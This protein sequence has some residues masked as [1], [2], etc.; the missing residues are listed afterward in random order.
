MIDPQLQARTTLDRELA[1]LRDNVLRLSY[2]VDTAIERSVQSLKD[3]DAALAQQVIADD[4]PINHMRYQIEEACY[5]LLAM[6]QPTARDMRSIVTAIH[7]VVE[8]ERIGDH[9]AGI[10]KISIELAKEPMLKPLI[11]VPRMAEISREMMR[12]SLNAYLEWDA[13]QARQTALRD[14]EVDTLDDQ[15]YRELLSFMLEDAHNIARATHLLWVSHNLERIADR[16]TNICERVIFMVTGQV[17]EI[18][19]HTH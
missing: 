13:E 4:E 1:T 16:I 11:D 12:A 18:G 15:V 3:Q 19:D 2:M 14:S 6:Q 8:L 9:A 10:A 7:I 5:R 17:S